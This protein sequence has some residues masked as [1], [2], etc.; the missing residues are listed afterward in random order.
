MHQRRIEG[1]SG[2]RPLIG[3]IVRS[4]DLDA[5]PVE[6]EVSLSQRRPPQL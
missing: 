5:W 2:D 1:D 4:P 6:P 3:A